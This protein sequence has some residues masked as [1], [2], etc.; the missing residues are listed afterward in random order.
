VDDPDMSLQSTAALVSSPLHVGSGDG[1]SLE[2]MPH[3]PA[4]RCLMRLSFRSHFVISRSLCCTLRA[5]RRLSAIALFRLK[6]TSSKRGALAGT[7]C[8]HFSC[9]NKK[10]ASQ[11]S[12]E[13]HEKTNSKPRKPRSTKSL[14]EE[15]T[16]Y[17]FLG[18]LVGENREKS[19]RRP[20]IGR[21]LNR[22]RHATLD[23][24]RRREDQRSHSPR[25]GSSVDRHLAETERPSPERHNFSGVLLPDDGRQRDPRLLGGAPT[26]P[27]AP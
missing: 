14:L 24:V 10:R 27:S 2:E 25:L 20:R 8:A 17:N 26:P 18:P 3:S 12:L 23:L 4:F 22:M 9:E 11:P 6:I 1:S 19:R 7:R 15:A 13:V 5:A 16:T 21:L